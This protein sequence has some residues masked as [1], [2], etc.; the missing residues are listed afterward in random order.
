MPG[1]LRQVTYE[2]SVSLTPYICLAM[3]AGSV[4]SSTRAL[5]VLGHMTITETQQFKGAHVSTQAAGHPACCKASER[6]NQATKGSAMLICCGH[7]VRRQGRIT[8]R[9]LTR[10]EIIRCVSITG[11]GRAAKN[12]LRYIFNILFGLRNF[13]LSV[14]FSR[15]RCSRRLA[16][17]SQRQRGAG[18]VCWI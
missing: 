6:P 13:R 15:F 1:T 2:S 12:E 11:E 17:Y 5:I 3:H 10:F 4:Q 16:R 7:S 9:R 8:C 18:A 14:T